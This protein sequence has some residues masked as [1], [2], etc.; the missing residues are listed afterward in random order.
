MS[1]EMFLLWKFFKHFENLIATNEDF[2]KSLE[3]KKFRQNLTCE[4]ESHEKEN[5]ELEVV[6]DVIEDDFSLYKKAKVMKVLSVERSTQA[7]GGQASHVLC[8]YC[9]YVTYKKYLLLRHMKNSHVD[10]TPHRCGKRF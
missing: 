9:N 6:K 1:T 7:A 10:K 2:V 3:K 8:N 5:P 4:N